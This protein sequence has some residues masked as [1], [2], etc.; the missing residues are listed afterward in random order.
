MDAERVNCGS[1]CGS[2]STKDKKQNKHHRH[3]KISQIK[4]KEPFIE[5]NGKIKEIL[6]NILERI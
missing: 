6:L 3:Q 1:K 5:I 2:F 4:L